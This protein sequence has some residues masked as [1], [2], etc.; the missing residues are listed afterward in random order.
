MHIQSQDLALRTKD[1]HILL[2]EGLRANLDDVYVNACK[3]RII[4]L[5]EEVKEHEQTISRLKAKL[6]VEEAKLK[7]HI[8]F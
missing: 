4:K 6:K 5:K 7:K 1:M 3:A 8:S 2:V